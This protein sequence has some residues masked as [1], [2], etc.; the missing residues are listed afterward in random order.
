MDDIQKGLTIAHMACAQ[1]CYFVLQT[2]LTL[3]FIFW[4]QFTYIKQYI[5]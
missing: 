4:Y 5:M 2:I 1:V 3:L